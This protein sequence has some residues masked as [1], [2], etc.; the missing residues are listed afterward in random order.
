MRLK[1]V[2]SLTWTLIN[3]H[4]N[5]PRSIYHF[6]RRERLW[7][8]ALIAGVIVLMV[9]MLGPLY[10]MLMDTMYTQYEAAGII[11]LFLANPFIMANLFGLVFGVFLMVSIFFFG[12]DMRVLVSLPL[13]ST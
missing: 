13:K 4:Y 11:E 6:R 9:V 3:S 8:P 2:I 10:G 7:E 5:I 12:E 1:M